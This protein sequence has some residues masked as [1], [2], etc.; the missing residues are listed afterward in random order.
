MS[1]NPLARRKSLFVAWLAAV[2]LAAGSP[3]LQA[4]P[5]PPPSPQD[6][7]RPEAAAAEQPADEDAPPLSADEADIAITAT[8]R[9]RELRFAADPKVEVRFFGQPE[10]VTES[11]TERSN[12]PDDVQPGVTYRDIGVRLKI[13]SLFADIDRIVAEALGEVPVQETEPPQEEVPPAGEG[14]QR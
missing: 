8:V 13:V 11:G 3:A 9:A 6:Q 12:L 10:R 14:R 1:D 5:S 2:T 4:Q 7:P